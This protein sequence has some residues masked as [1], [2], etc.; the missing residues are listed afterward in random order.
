MSMDFEKPLVELEEKMAE[1]VK[2][3]E[4]EDVKFDTEIAELE[5]KMKSISKKTYS[6]LTPWQTVQVARHSQRP[7]IRDYITGMCSEFIELHGDRCFG[8]DQG[9][10]GGFAKIDDVRVML[11]GH[12]KGKTV[13]ENI[14]S[15]FGMAN[16]EGY[17]KALRLM[18]LAEKYRIPVLSLIDTPGAYPGL[19]AEARGQAEAI[20]RNLMEMATLETPIVVVIT[21][22]GGSGGAIGIGVGDV[23]LM[24]SNSVYSVISPEGCA[25]ILW[26]DGSKAPVAADALKLTA[27]SLLELGVIDEIIKEPSGGAHRSYSEALPAVKETILRHLEKLSKVSGRKL[28]ER[29]FDKYAKIGRF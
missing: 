1:L 26:R 24:L 20:A 10:I 7:L 27:E 6:K 3:N 12:Q 13:E 9:I 19:E 16:P 2:L 11:I 22:E 8:D 28:T 25:S 5:K 15:N 23:V 21:G 4:N 29:R 18:K 17:R 14:K